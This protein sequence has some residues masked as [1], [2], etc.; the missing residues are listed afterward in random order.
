MVNKV[1]NSD[2]RF[3]TSIFVALQQIIKKYKNLS[4]TV[5]MFFPSISITYL[6]KLNKILKH[7]K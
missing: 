4:S 1:E 5:T 3:F 7:G 2:I 6:V